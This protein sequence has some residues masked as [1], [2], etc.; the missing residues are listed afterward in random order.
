MGDGQSVG[1]R[2]FC[3]Q[4]QQWRESKSDDRRQR[5]ACDARD[6][7][8]ER[9]SEEDGMPRIGLSGC[10]A[11]GAQH[12][13]NLAK[14]GVEL[15]FH[16]RTRSKAEEFGSRFNGKVSGGYEALV[17]G[18]DAIVIAT[19]PEQHMPQVLAAL[20]AGKPV[21]VEK[22]LCATVQELAQIEAAAEAAPAKAFVLIA[23]NYY[24]KPSLA[25]MRETITWDGIGAVQFMNVKKL[26]QQNAES[27]KAAYGA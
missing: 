3:I 16:N 23:E 15:V 20:A 27:W 9:M 8:H 18:C 25:L 26:T 7:R 10:G 5:P 19:P 12:A 4:H 17:E 2:R 22:P 1:P 14:R 24:Y 11:I 21:M 6:D 13:G